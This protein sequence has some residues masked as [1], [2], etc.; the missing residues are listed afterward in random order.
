MRV[1]RI[2]QIAAHAD[3]LEASRAFYRDTLG[4]RL[5]ATFDPPGL[6]FFDF[7]GTR[8]LLDANAA[9]ATIYFEVDD[10]HAAHAELRDR[11]VTFEGDPRLVHRDDDGIFGDPGAEEWMAFF[12]DPGGNVLALASRR[13]G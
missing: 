6:V 1:S 3:D 5:L 13:P 4:A 11:G 8:L 10:I 12:R 2:H 7:E 9:P